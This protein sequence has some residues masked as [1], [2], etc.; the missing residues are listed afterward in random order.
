MTSMG[1]TLVVL[2]NSLRVKFVFLLSSY[3]IKYE[4]LSYS[5]VIIYFFF[6]TAYYYYYLL[7]CVNITVVRMY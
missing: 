5:Y 1:G 4:T 3:V 7:L 2:Y 6:I